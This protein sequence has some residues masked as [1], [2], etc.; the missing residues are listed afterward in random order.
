[1]H[2]DDPDLGAAKVFFDGCLRTSNQGVLERLSDS[3]KVFSALES[4]CDAN[5]GSG[6]FDLTETLTTMMKMHL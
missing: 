4:L 5:S 1:M 2:P 6:T 3:M